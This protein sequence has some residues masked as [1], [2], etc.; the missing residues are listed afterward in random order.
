[1]LRTQISQANSTAAT[2]VMEVFMRYRV[3]PL[4]KTKQKYFHLY[5]DHLIAKIL[6]RVCSVR[7][8]PSHTAGIY[9]R[10]DRY[11]T[12]RIVG[13]QYLY[14]TR[15]NFRYDID[16]DTPLRPVQPFIPESDISVSSVPHQS[17]YEILWPTCYLIQYLCWTLR[18]VRYDSNTGTSGTDMVI[19]EPIPV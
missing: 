1:M 8:V 6:W 16:T 11:R 10:Y 13:H 5:K 17:R 2:M 7:Y 19:S 15:W 14:R 4:S 12:L 18:S 9:R 3:R